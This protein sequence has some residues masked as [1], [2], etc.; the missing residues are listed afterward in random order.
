[1]KREKMSH[2]LK[3]HEI[4]KTDF[5]RGENCY[6]YDSQG[7]RFVDFESGIWST[8]LGHNHPRINQVIESQIGQVMHLGTRYPSEIAEKAASEVL[9]ILGIERGKCTF[10]SSGSEAVEF[11]VRS[12]RMVSNKT[13]L[14]T[15]TSSYLA[16]Y[17]SAG[18]KQEDE[19]LLVDWSAW[20]QEGTD[21]FL[22]QIAFE[23][24]GAFVF[25]PGGSGSGFVK[26]PPKKLVE[27][28]AQRVKAAGGLVVVNEVTTGMGRTGTWFGFQHYDLQPDMVALGK[29]LGNGYPISAVAMATSCSDPIENNG[30]VYAQSHQNDPLGC[31]V[32]REVI[33]IM[34]EENWVATGAAR[35]AYFLEGLKQLQGKYEVIKDVRGRGML[36]ALEFHPHETIDATWAY[37]KLL[38]N[39]FLVG[40]YAAGNILR[41]DPALT[42]DRDDIDRLLDGMDSIFT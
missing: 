34:R 7:Q 21:E 30:F 12:A 6:L 14:L 39:G 37:Q 42:I 28:I 19:W 5:A 33:A 13:R 16:A 3:C 24:I 27:E 25:E 41:F 40:F 26:F 4:A 38:E 35:G 9:D 15:F 36:L 2:I 1:M 10:L 31:S 20:E 23:E 22:N 18:R 29:G 17:G 11:T 32:A 8:A